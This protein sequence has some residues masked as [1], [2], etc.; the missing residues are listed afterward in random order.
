MQ[1]YADFVVAVDSRDVSEPGKP[2]QSSKRLYDLLIQ[3]QR[4]REA[5]DELNRQINDLKQRAATGNSVER[6]NSA[7]RRDESNESPRR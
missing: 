1:N 5:F 4:L 7:E 2:S 3:S 6:L